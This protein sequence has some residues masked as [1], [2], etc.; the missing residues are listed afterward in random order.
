MLNTWSH[1]SV[2]DDEARLRM[3]NV[4]RRHR[5]RVHGPVGCF[6]AD[7]EHIGTARMSMTRLSYGT[8]VDV[9]GEPERGFWM[10]SLP[11]R[12]RVVVQSDGLR[13]DS[14]PGF[15]SLISSQSSGYGRWET[16]AR[17]A[18]FRLHEDLLK[19]AADSAGLCFDTVSS[20]RLL[21]VPIGP[22]LGVLPGLLDTLIRLDVD[23]CRRLPSALLERQWHNAATMI[24]QAVVGSD[25]E[26]ASSVNWGAQVRP[27]RRLL[28]AETWLRD[29]IA[30]GEVPD[31][32]ALARHLGL[33]LRTLQLLTRQQ[34]GMTA[35][36]FIE[37]FRLHHA[38]RLLRHS[39]AS[40]RDVA[41]ACG[42]NHLG[43][44]AASY[45]QRF[46]VTPNSDRRA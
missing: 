27:G 10:F 42:F 40:V 32:H 11:L 6:R 38:R 2:D 3:G 30:A 29:T 18:I 8:A 17:Q 25:P 45:F 34:R 44:F 12:G 7:M 26:T 14:R 1:S 35:H 41:I 37:E 28:E 13:F 36:Q 22:Q 31:V 19:E 15:A 23:S 21:G 5:L 4:L 46:T 16:G 43:R 39:S 9:E 33:S 20:R 24:A